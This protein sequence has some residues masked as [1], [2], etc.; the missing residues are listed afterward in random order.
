MANTGSADVLD[1][2]TAVFTRVDGFKFGEKEARGKKRTMGPSAATVGDGFIYVGDRFS[3][4]VCA[5]DGATLAPGKCVKLPSPPDGVAYVPSTK[6]VWVTTPRDNSLSVLD[7]SR[8]SVLKPRAVVKVD[9]APEGYAVDDSRGVFYTN[10]EDKG[11]TVVIDLKTRKPTATWNAGCGEDG[12][13][14]VATDV[15]R[16]FVFV[17]CTD[18][19]VVL[20]AAHDGRV[21]GKLD[22]GAGVDNLDWLDS[23]RLLYVAAAKASKV[24]IASF[25]DRG[26]PTVVATGASADGARNPVADATGNAYVADPKN[27]GILVFPFAAP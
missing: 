19:V 8:P 23:H 16:G 2:T 24:T 26:Q 12:P 14:G 25:D 4:E 6:E 22:T 17:A 10:L 13:R 3:G 27:G 15:A 5:V 18:H 9:G 11:G 20:D 7:A 1:A 21:L